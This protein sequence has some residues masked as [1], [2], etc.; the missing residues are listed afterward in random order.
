M[1]RNARVLM[2]VSSAYTRLEDGR[3]AAMVELVIGAM[4]A[5]VGFLALT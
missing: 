3:R 2:L 4:V 1:T 5:F